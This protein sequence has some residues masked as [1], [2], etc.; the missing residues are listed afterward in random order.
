MIAMAQFRELLSE[1]CLRQAPLLGKLRRSPL[2]GGFI[3]YVSYKALP[4]DFQVWHEIKGGAAKGLWI[5]VNPRTGRAICE[6]TAEPEIQKALVDY[7]RPGMVFYD[8]GAN[9]GLYTLAAARLV[10]DTGKVFSIEPD[11]EV[12]SRL[13]ENTSYN[14]FAWVSTFEVALWSRGGD[15][16]FATADASVSPDHGLGRIVENEGARNLTSVRATTLDDFCRDN[17]VPDLLKCDVEGAEVEVLRGA[18]SLLRCHHPAIICE[19]HSPE[20]ETGVRQI[21]KQHSYS[22]KRLDENHLFAETS[23]K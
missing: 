22:V 3:H 23:G 16:A 2:I 4:P 14:G 7:L 19:V 20:C 6:G 15:I 8:A 17:A 13:R 12:V 18:A 21:L 5:K 10:G 11:A 9:V 1:I